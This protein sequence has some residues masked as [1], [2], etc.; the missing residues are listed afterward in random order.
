MIENNYEEGVKRRID[1]TYRVTG[2]KAKHGDDD[3]EHKRQAKLRTGWRQGNAEMHQK[4]HAEI[5]PNKSK[6]R[7]TYFQRTQ[8]SSIKF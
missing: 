8:K 6:L 1:L 5:G 2:N 7:Q 3:G 4:K